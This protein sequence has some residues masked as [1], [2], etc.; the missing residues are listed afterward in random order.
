MVS[1]GGGRNEC[2]QLPELECHSFPAHNARH[3]ATMHDFA[4]LFAARARARVPRGST[5]ACL[6]AS[7]DSHLFQG[8]ARH[9]RQQPPIRPHPLSVPF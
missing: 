7:F 5:R 6:Q 4:P 8:E 2:A 3:R 1:G 9:A